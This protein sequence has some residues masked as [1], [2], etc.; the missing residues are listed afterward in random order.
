MGP[1]H[2]QPL[3]QETL[4]PKARFSGKVLVL[5]SLLTG[6]G[7]IVYVGNTT[8]QDP[9]VSMA[10]QFMQPKQV[11]Q[12]RQPTRAFQ[13]VPP[14]TVWQSMQPARA[15]Q[16][17]QSAVTATSDHADA[18][19]GDLGRRTA[20]A[21]GLTSAA[22]AMVPPMANAGGRFNVQAIKDGEDAEDVIQKQLAAQKLDRDRTIKKSQ[23]TKEQIEQED[24]AKLGGVAA[25]GGLTV[26]SL[27]FFFPNLQRL[28]TKVGSG[29]KDDGYG[30]PPPNSRRTVTGKRG[31]RR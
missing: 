22:M 27:P 12:I 1:Y 19:P 5:V 15:Q 18:S 14:A 2:T 16:F 26:L 6:L 28:A 7:L 17:R 20:L 21:A 9:T 13:A 10:S 30:S 31:P 8:V 29:G 11:Q 3:I 25:V 4:L 24:Q 23:R